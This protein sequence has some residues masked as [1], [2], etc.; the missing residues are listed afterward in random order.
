MK[1]R[2]QRPEWDKDPPYEP[3][4]PYTPDDMRYLIEYADGLASDDCDGRTYSALSS[5]ADQIEALQ[6]RAENA[7]ADRDD[8]RQ[9]LDYLAAGY[10]SGWR[11]PAEVDELLIAVAAMAHCMMWATPEQLLSLTIED[12][13]DY[14]EL[15]RQ[16]LA[17]LPAWAK[18]RLSEPR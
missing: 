4:G 1:E 9:R 8:L 15:R 5:A 13:Q 14:A 12:E 16:A 2:M 7:E 18:E 17:A 10:Q 11:S 6:R 3:K